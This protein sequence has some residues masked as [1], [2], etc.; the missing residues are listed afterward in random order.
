MNL[1]ISHEVANFLD[2]GN[3]LLQ[4]LKIDGKELSE[5]EVRILSAQLRQLSLEIKRLDCT[6][7]RDRNKEAA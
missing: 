2:Y 1:S 7:V 6:R 5:M 4:R 3:R